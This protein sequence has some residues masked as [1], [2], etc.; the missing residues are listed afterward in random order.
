M[1]KY[2]TLQEWIEKEGNSHIG[3]NGSY[4][5][6]E[7]RDIPL[8]AK[9]SLAHIYGHPMWEGYGR[10]LYAPWGDLE[11]IEKTEQ[12]TFGAISD[13][14]G[15]GSQ[16][17][18]EDLNRMQDL[19][20]QGK[21]AVHSI[22][23]PEAC[24]EENHKACAQIV[25]FKGNPGSPLALVAAGGGYQVVCS[26]WEGYPYAMELLSQGYH[27][28]VLKYRT[29]YQL[30]AKD[31][32]GQRREAE[33]DMIQA[34]RFLT[35]HQEQLGIEMEN[36]TMIG[37]SAGGRLITQFVFGYY[38]SLYKR[39]GLPRPAT[40]NLIYTDRFLFYEPEWNIDI[41]FGEADRDL[42][43][44]CIVG[45]MDAFGG[46]AVM[47]RK[48]PELRAALGDSKVCYRKF[49]AGFYHGAGLGTGT[50]GEGWLQA[51]IDFWKEQNGGEL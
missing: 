25:L 33:E 11:T 48:M 14:C 4:A 50:P 21:M 29:G 13:W 43:V 20:A 51:A 45:E 26:I 37:S 32:L 47:D 38:G 18:L 10:N 22:Y 19:N 8:S 34:V 41:T 3:E 6:A 15:W 7:G 49:P 5:D 36:Y 35:E 23:P 31:R 30:K 46:D 9:D 2:D 40:I 17:S 24:S 27:V 44:F 39:E 1:H 12:F 42:A 16:R 28:A